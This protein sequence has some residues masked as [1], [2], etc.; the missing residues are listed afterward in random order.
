M[1]YTKQT[2]KLKQYQKTIFEDKK[3]KENEVGKSSK[4]LFS[5]NIV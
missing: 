3:G 1:H 5:N 2:N 4:I